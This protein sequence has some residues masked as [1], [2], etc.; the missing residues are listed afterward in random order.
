MN[1]LPGQHNEATR[2]QSLHALKVLDTAPEV[3]FD[4]LARAAAA[5]CGA[6]ISLISLVDN[7][8]QWFKANHGLPGVSQTS[9]EAAFCAHT[10]AQGQMLE[11]EDAWTDPR[12]ASNPLVLGD[13]HIRFYAG[14]PIRLKDGA[15][16]GALCV[17]DRAPRRLN[18]Q[19][20]EVLTQL[21]LAVAHALEG[22]RA[23]LMAGQ[24]AADLRDS[25]ARFR[26]LSE[27]APL[28]V[29][30]TDAEGACTYTN[31]RWQAIYGLDLAQSLGK[32]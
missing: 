31:P 24:A 20:R 32:R 25:E 22:R 6:P 13:P 17:V 19:Q 7:E 11:I 4:A 8:R 28:G 10:V 21:A 14:A 26:T 23:A 5:V 1:A 12:F 27:H 15:V 30:H 18:I 2:L 16:V 9:R 3:E 29:F